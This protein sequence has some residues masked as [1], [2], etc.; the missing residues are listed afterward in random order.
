MADAAEALLEALDDDAL[1]GLAER[2]EHAVMDF[3]RAFISE[4]TARLR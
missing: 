2:L 1:I 3:R 4:Q